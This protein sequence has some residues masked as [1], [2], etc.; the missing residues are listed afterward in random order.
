M[1]C[2]PVSCLLLFGYAA[3]YPLTPSSFSSFLAA[4]NREWE[5]AKRIPLPAVACGPLQQ[6]LHVP[7]QNCR[8][9]HLNSPSRS[10]HFTL[11]VKAQTAHGGD[12]GEFFAVQHC[13][14]YVLL[15]VHVHVW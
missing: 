7:A 4:R 3:L 15:C 6:Q 8:L 5:S 2:H 1:F 12:G 11:L 14:A 9:T 13:N 10:G